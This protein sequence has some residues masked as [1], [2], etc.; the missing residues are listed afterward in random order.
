MKSKI[1]SQLEFAMQKGLFVYT[2]DSRRDLVIA[3]SE[4]E[5]FEEGKCLRVHK[6]MD[7]KTYLEAKRILGR[8]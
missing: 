5:F 4:K 3:S 6:G 7:E 1:I 2:R 8:A